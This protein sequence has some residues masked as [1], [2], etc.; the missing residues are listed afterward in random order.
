[1]RSGTSEVVNECVEYVDGERAAYSHPDPPMDFW[2]RFDFVADGPD[3]C[4]VTATVRMQPHGAL[5]LM[6]PLFRLRGPARSARS[7]RRM[8]EVVE[9][10]PMSATGTMAG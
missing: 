1:M 5:R 8:R 2:I 7:S 6:T 10:T 9:E 4:L 3:A